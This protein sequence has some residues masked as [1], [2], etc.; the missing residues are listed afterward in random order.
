MEKK[1]SILF[2]TD[3]IVEMDAHIEPCKTGSLDECAR[4]VTEFKDT[5]CSVEDDV[6]TKLEINATVHSFINVPGTST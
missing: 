2:V 6:C 4:F 1:T 5:K 3:L